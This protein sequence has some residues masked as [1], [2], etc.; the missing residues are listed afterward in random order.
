MKNKDLPFK[1]GENYENWEFDL[2]ILD[3]ER[4]KGYDGYI[5]IRE[6]VFLGAIPRYVELIFSI[7]LLQIVI[8]NY[9][10]QKSDLRKIIETLDEKLMLKNRLDKIVIYSID[11]NLELWV[12][13]KESNSIVVIYGIPCL[14]SQLYIDKTKNN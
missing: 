7:D 3:V 14:L 13:N 5:Y 10:L 2:E 9:E 8:F 11:V 12:I 1:I 6:I 4:I